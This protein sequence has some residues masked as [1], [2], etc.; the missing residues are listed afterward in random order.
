MD[1]ESR[2]KA[3]LSEFKNQQRSST[4]LSQLLPKIN[5]LGNS[6]SA[7]DGSSSMW[8][9]ITTPLLS[10]QSSS[11]SSTNA[12]SFGGWFSASSSSSDCFG[13]SHAQVRLSLTYY[14]ILL[15]QR[16][17]GFVLCTLTAALFFILAFTTL[18]L[19]LLS[20]QKFVLFYTFGSLL[21]FVR[22]FFR[23]RIS[24]LSLPLTSSVVSHLSVVC[25]PFCPI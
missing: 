2:F 8:Q 11:S 1:D 10:G 21:A 5:P 3:S 15:L 14:G 16:M 25:G 6:T 7:N 23:F 13:L 4:P 19:V 17:V 24:S 20:P 9:N 12:R 22:F 18:P